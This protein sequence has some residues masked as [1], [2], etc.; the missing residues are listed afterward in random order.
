MNWYHLRMSE[1]NFPAHAARGGSGWKPNGK[2]GGLFSGIADWRRPLLAWLGVQLQ[3]AESSGD[4]A[5]AAQIRRRMALV[6][7]SR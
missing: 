7:E 2:S 5:G 3:R 1:T 6:G 4:S